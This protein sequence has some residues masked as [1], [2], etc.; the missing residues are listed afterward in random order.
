M[1]DQRIRLSRGT[2]L[3]CISA[4]CLTCW[5][6][7]CGGDERRTASEASSPD[8]KVREVFSPAVQLPA[9]CHRWPL[10]DPTEP[11]APPR[12]VAANGAVRGGRR[13]ATDTGPARPPRSGQ[14]A[15]GGL[16]APGPL[17]ETIPRRMRLGVPATAQVR[18]SR[19]KIDGLIH[20]LLSGRGI[21][22]RPDGFLARSLSVRLKAPDGGFWIEPEAPET[23]WVASGPQ[24]QDE[25]AAWQWTV[26]P[27]WRGKARLLLLVTARTVGRDGIASEMAPPDRV[28]EVAVK[29]RPLRR[30]GRF[31]G[32]LVTVAFGAVLGR[33]GGEVWTVAAA[34]LRR[35]AG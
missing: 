21:A 8:E 17:V 16:A 24:Q 11:A 2:R 25:F 28:I 27:Q 32:F 34:I 3:P 18:I 19:D 4:L 23:Q 9:S 12:P 26:T 20:L 29:G 1:D 14:R 6:A 31:L 10:P 33:F 15:G 22:Y 5:L 13:P 7:G 35:L 30:L